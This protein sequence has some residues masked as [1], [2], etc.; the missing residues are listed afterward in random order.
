M[1]AIGAGILVH[2]DVDSVIAEL[3]KAV[4]YCI[5]TGNTT[6]AYVYGR[7]MFRYVAAMEDAGRIVWMDGYDYAE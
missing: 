5:A 6:G 2:W 3:L 1:I 4:H 7:M